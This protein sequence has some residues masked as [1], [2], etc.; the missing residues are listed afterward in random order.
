MAIAIVIILFVIAFSIYNMET[1][2]AIQESGKVRKETAIFQGVKDLATSNDET[3]NTIDP[4]HPTYRSLDLSINQKSGAEYSYNFWMY[5]SSN[6]RNIIG[7][8]AQSGSP[9]FADQGLTKRDDDGKLK[10]MA[11]DDQPLVL[12]LRG[13]KRAFVYKSLCNTRSDKDVKADVLM[14]NPLIKLEQGGDVLTVELNTVSG[15]DAVKEK[16]RSTCDERNTDWEYMNSHK[17]ALKGLSTRDELADRWFMVTVVVHD[18]FPTDPYPIRNKVRVRIYVNGVI[19]LDKYLDTKLSQTRGHASTVKQSN[20]N[21]HVAPV[22][23]LLS[24]T[25]MELSKRISSNNANNIRMADLTYFNYALDAAAV[26]NLF[27]NGF[28]KKI[29][30]GV[31]YN[32]SNTDNSFMDQMSYAGDKG[33]LSE[34]RKTEAS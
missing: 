27:S 15:P 4:N 2:K 32:E 13:D 16:S 11:L 34:V 9:I 26:T 30:P 17:V 25:G 22:I 6:T 18:T 1:I 20:S 10:K 33:I 31:A 29:A 28:T 24:P 23:R 12:L 19:E 7:T 8:P 3:Y 14:K 21:L 5:L